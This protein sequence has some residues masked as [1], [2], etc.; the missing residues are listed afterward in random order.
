MTVLVLRHERFEHLGH[1][2][3]A[4][5]SRDIPYIYKDVDES[6][7]SGGYQGIVVLGGPQ[8]ANDP[9][10]ADELNVIERGL[11]AGMPML[12]ICLGSQLIAK[13]L[14]ARVYR[15]DRLEIGWEPVHLTDAGRTDPVLGGIGS[16]AMVFH[17]HGETFDLP[18]GAEWLAWSEKTRHQAY[19]Y[20]S[21]VWGLQFHPEVTA[22]MVVDWSSQA[23]N[24]GDVATLDHPIDAHAVDQQPIADRIVEGWLSTR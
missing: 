23:C 8:S 19:R 1:F 20:G 15:N 22:E 13:A 24:C 14:G 11:R 12:G 18:D 16:P 4:F 10:L 3:R 5:E 17:W 21:N 7:P 9:P 2:A 6:V